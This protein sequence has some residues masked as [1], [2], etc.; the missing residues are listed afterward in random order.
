VDASEFFLDHLSAFEDHIDGHAAAKEDDL[1]EFRGLQGLL[2]FLDLRD[3][4][5]LGT[6][7]D[8]FGLG[9]DDGGGLILVCVH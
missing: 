5:V 2:A 6:D 3:D 7:A 9:G 8:H 4:V 1:G